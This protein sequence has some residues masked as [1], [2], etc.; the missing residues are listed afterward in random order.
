MIIKARGKWRSKMHAV[1]HIDE[2]R[3]N[4][5]VNDVWL[6]TRVVIQMFCNVN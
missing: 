4:E 6:C 5:T 1:I 3:L 2:S